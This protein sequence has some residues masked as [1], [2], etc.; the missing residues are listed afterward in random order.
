MEE[1]TAP[2]PTR[3]PQ[4]SAPA[5]PRRIR[6]IRRWYAVLA[7]TLHRTALSVG[8]HGCFN[9]AQSTAY[10]AVVA[11]FPALIVAA[12][13]IGLL[14][15]TAPVR[16]QLAA[17]FD[18]VLP[19]GVT[20]LLDAAFENSPGHAHS[21][22]AL[23]T[24]GFVSFLGAANIISTLMEGI[25]RA[26]S[27]PLNSWSFW[28]RR[29]R[30]FELVFLSLIP[31]A[32]ASLLI[33]FGHAF[34]H[35]LLSSIGPGLRAPLYMISVLVRWAVSFAASVGLIGL[36][37]HLGVPDG[38]LPIAF[39]P[40][41]PAAAIPA[42]IAG[43]GRRFRA[44]LR[45]ATRSTIGSTLITPSFAGAPGGECPIALPARSWRASLPGAVVATALWFFTT[46]AFGWYVTRFADYSQVYGSLGALI[47]LLFWLYIISLSV[48]CGAEF[49]AQFDSLL[50]ANA[51]RLRQ[52]APPQ[53][54]ETAQPTP[55]S[56]AT[57]R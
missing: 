36:I 22:R 28:Q 15:D 41:I 24:A 10:S 50:V 37:Y 21:L 5:R 42:P 47:A 7:R 48:L 49:N 38:A 13:F 26:R 2:T 14:P 1:L 12:A 16:F 8:A 18:R 30:T 51:E 25:R 45:I 9:L 35:W 52:P 27:L 34:T 39:H 4:P 40:P 56:P 54:T 3:A 57:E 43:A 11:L 55:P 53:P 31:L 20:P 32:A 33:V 23:F 6:R 17:F 44:L 46:L 29:R 19:P